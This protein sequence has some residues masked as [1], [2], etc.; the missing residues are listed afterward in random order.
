MRAKK[1][2]PELIDHIGWDLVRAAGAWKLQFTRAMVEHGFGWY[3][4]ARGALIQHIGH[5][6][7]AQSELAQRAGMTKQAVQQHLDELVKDGV[8]ERAADSGDGRRKLV[9]FTDRGF[10]ALEVANRIKRKIESDYLRAIGCAD[11]QKL[12]AA[13]RVIIDA[14]RNGL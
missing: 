6:G 14:D 8:L 11:M 12:Q 10:E 3:A 2:K 9:R 13:L 1:A 5:N 4:E 7:I